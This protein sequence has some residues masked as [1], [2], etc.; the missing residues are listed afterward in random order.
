MS[1]AQSAEIAKPQVLQY[2]LLEGR[3]L[4][5]GQLIG[6]LPP[7]IRDSE[8]MMEL[9]GDQRF[10]S[11]ASFQLCCFRPCTNFRSVCENWHSSYGLFALTLS[12]RTAISTVNLVRLHC[13]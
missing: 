12:P 1:I 11:I 3:L 2:H 4:I 9:F 8:I 6:K 10:V 13:I 7:E 5:D